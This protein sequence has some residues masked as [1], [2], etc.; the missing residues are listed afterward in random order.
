MKEIGKDIG[1]KSG[2]Y[3]MWM[4]YIMKKAT[5]YTVWGNTFLQCDSNVQIQSH[6]ETCA[7]VEIK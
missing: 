2:V 7:E 4:K 6:L 3:D 1:T 5:E